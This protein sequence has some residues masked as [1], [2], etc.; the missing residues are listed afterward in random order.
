M[1]PAAAFLLL[2]ALT[3]CVS[4]N[5]WRDPAVPLETVAVDIDSYM[6]RWH[7]IARFPNRFEEGCTQV[8][9]DYTRLSKGRVAVVNTCLRNGETEVARARARIIDAGKLTVSFLPERISFLDGIAAGDYWV[10]WVDADYRAAVVGAPSGRVG[11][12]LA[13]RPDPAA[14]L[15]EEA[16]AALIAAGYDTQGLIWTEEANTE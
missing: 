12:I 10:L 8:T 16:R 2:A 11:W 6:G 9:A 5:A 14:D 3:G 4:G 15:L 7:E 1:R 13:R